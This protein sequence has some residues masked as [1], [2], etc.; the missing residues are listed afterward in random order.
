MKTKIGFYEKLKQMH[1]A[2]KG[3]L[4][5]LALGVI[6]GI[7]SL[8]IGLYMI[9]KVS[10]IV[11]VNNTSDFYSIY[12]NLATNTSTVYDVMILVIIVVAL[13]VAIAVLRS[14]NSRS[15]MGESPSL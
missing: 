7:V 8:Y 6:V 5:G 1:E 13:G 4:S 10:D 2:R 3:S 12:T 15:Q 11:A 14:F 9:V